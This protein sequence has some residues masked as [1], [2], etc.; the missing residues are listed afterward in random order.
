MKTVTKYLVIFLVVIIPSNFLFPQDTATEELE[1]I[2]SETRNDTLRCELFDKISK[3]NLSNNP[4]KGREFAYEQLRLAEKL[5]LDSLITSA[6]IN[7]SNC[8]SHLEQGDSALYFAMQAKDHSISEG[9]KFLIYN[10]MGNSFTTLLN[11][12]SAEY[13]YNKALLSAKEEND[14]KNIAAAYNNLGLVFMD[15]GELQASYQNYLE[16]LKLFEKIGDRANQAIALNNIGIVNMDIENNEKA[17][18]YFQKAIEINLE[19]ND[20]LNL[21]MNYS[22]LGVIYKEMGEY[23]MALENY[24][25]SLAISEEYGFSSDLARHYFNVGNIYLETDDLKMAKTNFLKSLKISEELGMDL[26]LLYNNF[27]ISV[28]D[29]NNGLYADVE[30]R[31]KKVDELIEKSGMVRLRTDLLERYAELE[32]KRGDY[33]KSLEYYKMFKSHADSMQEVASKNKIEDIQTKYETEKKTLENEKLI[34]QAALNKKIIKNQRLLGLVIIISLFLLVLFFIILF[35]SRQKLHVAYESLKKLNKKVVL[36]KEKLEE[37]NETK[38]KMFSIIAHDLRSPFS[39]LLGFLEIL[40]SEFEE[41]DDKEKKE[42]LEIVNSQSVKT[43]GLLENLLQWAMMQRGMIKLHLSD[44]DLNNIAHAQLTELSARAN[45]KQIELINNVPQGFKIFIDE[46]VCKTILRNLVNNAIKF[47]G[48][49]GTIKIEAR[50]E[51]DKVIVKV[52]DNGIGMSPEVATNLFT[53]KIPTS[54]K[55]TD[56]ESG[57]GMGLR[58]VHDFIE[59]LK[60]EIKVESKPDGGSVFYLSFKKKEN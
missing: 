16:A 2:L 57:S 34:D 52:I 7:L 49:G 3:E 28:L 10:I 15:M 27:Q 9:D 41:M 38:D 29:L 37:V 46:T 23:G 4:A 58:I 30:K 12:D 40:I 33:R 1:I 24:N 11:L 51:S 18:D 39:S 6:F 20:N 25:K 54:T 19:L 59:L 53:K 17:I 35:R 43:Y 42:M 14:E 8:Y 22:N 44:Y 56:N 5:S 47:T 36:Q 31:L 60:A 45:S 21:S 48:R 55:G 26:G 32:E 50:E 13:Y